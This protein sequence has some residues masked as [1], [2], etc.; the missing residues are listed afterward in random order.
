MVP[1]GMVAAVSHVKA[2]ASWGG[3][4]PAT[5]ERLWKVFVALDGLLFNGSSAPAPTARRERLRG[6]L[7][8]IF[9]GQWGVAW[10]SGGPWRTR[11]AGALR[12][13]EAE[14]ASLRLECAESQSLR[15]Q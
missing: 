2:H 11:R 15:G 10:R 7:Q 14:G 6:R 12:R 5:P 13:A 1:D 8:W 3:M 4:P 9:A